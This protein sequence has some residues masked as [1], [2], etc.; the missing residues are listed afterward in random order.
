M[1]FQLPTNPCPKCNG[2]G[3][4]YNKNILCYRCG[5]A[6]NLKHIQTD[7]DQLC[8]VCNGHGFGRLEEFKCEYCNGKGYRDWVDEIIRR[9]LDE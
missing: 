3:F 7:Y 1:I 8:D 9:S 6:G 5:G 2:F 4:N